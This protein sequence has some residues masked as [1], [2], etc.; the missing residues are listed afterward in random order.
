DGRT[1][2]IHGGLD[3]NSHVLGDLWKGQ[4]RSSTD[5]AHPY[6]YQWVWTRLLPDNSTT[7]RYG[8]TMV[9]DPGPPRQN[10]GGSL[11]A[12]APYAQLL[13]FGGRTST[14]STSPMA[15][16][17]KLYT[18][19]VGSSAAVNGIWRELTPTA[20]DGAPSARE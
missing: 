10:S 9:F 11:L 2:Y 6:H 8:H 20:P 13:I 1:C 16:A 4:L 7:A 15:D 19:G 17:S 12:G 14:G 18:Y 3:A 5:A